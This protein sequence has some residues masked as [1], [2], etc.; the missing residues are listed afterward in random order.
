MATAQKYSTVQIYDI[1]NKVNSQMNGNS[2]IEV[3]DT[4]SFV[5][6]G[7]Q[8]LNSQ[9]L[10]EN[11]TNTLALRIALSI[12]SFRAYRSHFKPIVFDDIRWG[13][14]V[15]KIKVLMPEA[16]ED[17]AYDLVDGESIDMYEVRK[18]KMIQN[19]FVNS[20]PYSFFVTIQRWQLRR[21]FTSEAAFASLL[22]AIYGEIQN[23]LE[24][25]FE[26]LGYLTL[27]NFI[28]NM[29]PTQ[30]VKLLTMYNN[31][32]GSAIATPQ[33]AMFDGNYLR[34]A[35]AQMNIYSRNMATNSTLYNANGVEH[36]T[37][38]Q[39]QIFIIGNE[40]NEYMKTVVQYEAF[41]KEYVSKEASVIV[42]YWQNA[43]TPG[44]IQVTNS[45]GT[46]VTVSNIIGM[47]HD[48]DALGVYRK[49]QEVLTTP[50]NARGR[51]LNTFYHEEQMW[52]NDMNENGIVFLNA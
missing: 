35:I 36:H 24:I 28:G 16:V 47:I 1:V 34:F 45:A 31:L 26:N 41:H 32:T 12:I 38:A 11:F 23:K 22:S 14:I 17:K 50:L 46:D 48:R 3:V 15:Q 40:F 13:A 19:F 27:D 21:A 20:T 25:T 4:N 44:E 51:Y 29:K 2:G 49:E 37:P 43:E 18:P 6:L 42:P 5:A 33:A 52:F 9:E 7:Q 10:T 8:I 30:Q 39:D